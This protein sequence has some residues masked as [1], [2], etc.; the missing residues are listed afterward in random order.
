MQKL[1]F[2]KRA[3]RKLQQV[4]GLKKQKGDRNHTFSFKNSVINLS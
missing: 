4:A 1:F 2:K 3:G